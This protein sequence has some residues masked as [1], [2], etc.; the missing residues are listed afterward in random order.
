MLENSAGTNRPRKALVIGG[1]LSGLFAGNMLRSIGWD[2]DI[3]ERSASSLYG[4][5]AGV[6]LQSDVG[7]L[8]RALGTSI[9]PIMMPSCDHLVYDPSGVEISR[10]RASQVQ[11]SWSQIYSSMRELFPDEH[12]H[13]GKAL[14]RFHQTAKTVTAFFQ[15]GSQATGDL[16]IGADGGRS[17]VRRLVDAANMP[18]YAGY[19]AWR[20]VI[21]NSDVPGEGRRLLHNFASSTNAQSHILGYP[22]PAT[23]S[24]A[25]NWVWYRPIEEF[26]D[27]PDLMTD[28]FGKSRPYSIPPGR[29]SDKWLDHVDKDAEALLPPA[30]KALVQATPE[31]FAQAILDLTSERTVYNRALLLGEA[32][33]ILRPHMGIGTAKAASDALQLGN[34]LKNQIDDFEIDQ[35]LA[36]WQRR[37]TQFG[38]QLYEQGVEVG[39]R[40]LFDSDL[41]TA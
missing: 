36:Q 35:A 10:N 37:Q 40:L 17:A 25:F 18:Q 4:R 3:Y 14:M 38:Q 16:L 2:V 13:Q 41:A 23:G 34:L 27:L 39:T 31:P 6:V 8:Y 15:D 30:F 24:G 7:D 32:A 1:S 9:D 21:H 33:F 26:S 19:I 28:R 22:V 20:G 5:G 11:T 29:L 12:Y